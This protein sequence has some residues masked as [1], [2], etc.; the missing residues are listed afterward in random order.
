MANT[1]NYAALFQSNLDKLME[2]SITT[3][4]AEANANRVQYN[5]GNEIKIAKLGLDGLADYSRATGYEDGS[6]TLEWETHKFAYDRGRKF[7]IDEIGRASCR[8]RV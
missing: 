8:E 7:T 1:I 2:Q 3:A 6:V 4:W 5:G